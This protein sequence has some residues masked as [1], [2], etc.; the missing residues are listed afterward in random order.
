MHKKVTHIFRMA[1]LVGLMLILFS[2]FLEWY[3]FQ[4]YNFDNNLDTNGD[5]I[6]ISDVYV[7]I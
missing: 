1:D 6:L 4:I 7:A 3:S 2:V 5:S